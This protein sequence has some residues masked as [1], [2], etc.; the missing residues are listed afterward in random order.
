MK[1][2]LTLLTVSTLSTLIA[3][4][5]G[6]VTLET[7]TKQVNNPEN[8]FN[9]SS[10]FKTSINN[11]LVN[12]NLGTINTNGLEMPNQQQIKKAIKEHNSPIDINNITISDITKTSAK[13][14]GINIYE[15]TTNVTFKV[16]KKININDVLKNTNLGEIDNNNVTPT[17]QQLKEAIL[18]NN[19]SVKI[20]AII[21]SNITNT[22]AKITGDDI[23]YTGTVVV[24]YSVTF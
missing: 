2:L 22:S 4:S 1:N 17:E 13:V 10:T 16:Y 8:V 21:I 5:S 3:T 19:P 9:D 20:E 12:T 14:T 15:G 7:M 11:I 18:A 23:L 6:L 24:I